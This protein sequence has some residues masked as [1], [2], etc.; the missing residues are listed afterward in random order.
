M[1]TSHITN[2]GFRPEQALYAQIADHFKTQ[3]ALGKLRPGDRLPSIR[4]LAKKLGLDPGTVARAYR[5]LE[6]QG[7]ISGRRGGGSF[8]AASA[9]EKHLA[10]QHRERLGVLLEKTITEALGLGF[11]VEDVEAAFTLRLAGW[12]ERR[13]QSVSTARK[14]TQRRDDE[15]RFFGSHDMAVELLASHLSSLYPGVR[16][17]PSF[18]GSLAG[19]MALQLGEADISGAHLLDVDSGEFNAPFIRRLMPGET[20]VL[21]NLMQRVQGL[22]LAPGNPRHVTGISDLPRKDVT[23]VNRQRGSGTRILLD[24]QLRSLGIA[25]ADVRGYERE[26]KTHIGIATFIAG[27]QA[28]TGLGAQSAAS[29]AGL[30][31]IPLFKERYDLVIL[32]ASFEQPRMQMIKE[33]VASDTFKDMMGAMPGYD[34]SQTGRIITVRPEQ[35]EKEKK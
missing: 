7:I 17:I 3:V 4:E 11:T 20:V 15:I 10:E 23:F 25:P 13:R 12:R 16:L 2:I 26:E 29:V 34:L 14:V 9:T 31:F 24:A 5:E 33:V 19:L 18:V 21:M 6:G 32:Q 30:D 27:G 1:H 8:V 28:D 22:M 35:K